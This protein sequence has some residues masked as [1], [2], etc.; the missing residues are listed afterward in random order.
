MGQS[1]IAAGL[2]SQIRSRTAQNLSQTFSAQLFQAEQNLAHIP[3]YD[4]QRKFELETEIKILKAVV[5]LCQG[6]SGG[7]DA[8]LSDGFRGMQVG[9]H[10][11]VMMM[12]TGHQSQG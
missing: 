5:G 1:T 12:P 10:G 8:G 2:E 4:V 7:T 9:D 6:F 11:A 3:P